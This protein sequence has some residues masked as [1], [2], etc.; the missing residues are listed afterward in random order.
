M[1]YQRAYRRTNPALEK[2]NPSG[3]KFSR[4]DRGARVAPAARG[5]IGG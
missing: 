1:T 5:V 2:S 4:G 3:T